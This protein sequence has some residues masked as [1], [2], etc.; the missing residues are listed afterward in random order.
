MSSKGKV[1]NQKLS[2]IFKLLCNEDFEKFTTLFYNQKKDFEK[3][4]SDIEKSLDKGDEDY[5]NDEKKEYIKLKIDDKFQ[6]RKKVVTKWINRN[7]SVGEALFKAD[8]SNFKIGKI[9]IP[10]SD[11]FLF[12]VNDFFELNLDSFKYKI[13]DY[14]KL[15]RELSLVQDT[16]Y[17]Y[18]YFYNDITEDIDYY[19]IKYIETDSNDKSKVRIELIL[20][21][22]KNTSKTYQGYLSYKKSTFT[23]NL[24][25]K[26]SNLIL[27]FNHTLKSG[28]L[29]SIYHNNLYGIAL[30][31]NIQGIPKSQKVILR[32]E[33]FYDEDLPRIYLLLNEMEVLVA[34]ENKYFYEENSKLDI[35]HLEQYKNK[36]SRINSFF[37]KI[38]KMKEIKTTFYY[39]LAIREFHSIY[40][41]FK[42]LRQNQDYYVKD[43]KRVFTE[44]L[45]SVIY[46]NS[47]SCSM[48]IPAFIKKSNLFLYIDKNGNFYIKDK[49]INLSNANIQVNI[50]FV[51]NNIKDFNDNDFQEIFQD[52]IKTK[53][54]IKFIFKK[55]IENN[56]DSFDFFFDDSNHEIVISKKHKANYKV[57]DIETQ[58]K[59]I[60][61]YQLTFEIIKK[62]SISYKTLLNDT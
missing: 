40:A 13:N 37:M 60:S 61:E 38:K 25:S 50:I 26:N 29:K 12:S 49:V 39:S 14:L 43:R 57:F 22:K 55:H 17:K 27:L 24:E 48:I 6:N 51:L 36:I 19:E 3:I 45:D 34:N 1:L 9:K 30:D 2:L 46:H 52:L 23:F 54:N 31:N 18:I 33:K 32:Q 8:F 10:M 15:K 56:V 5:T 16:S 4:E 42:K 41:I 58:S 11:D 59:S 44:F 35:K 20:L 47:T 62:Q 28:S 21:D 7:S 53:I